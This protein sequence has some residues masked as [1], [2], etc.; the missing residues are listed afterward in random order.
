[1]FSARKINL[2]IFLYVVGLLGFAIYSELY[3]SMYPCPLCITQRFFFM[4]V[5]ITA[6]IAAL[7]NSDSWWRRLYPILGLVFAVIGGAFATRHIWLQSLPE[8]QVP[9]CGPSSISYIL[10]SFPA[11]EALEIL[12]KGDGNCAKVDTI[13]GVSYALWSFLGFVLLSLVNI[14]QIFR[15]A[16]R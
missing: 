2:G 15:K 14:Y 3:M 13:L 5:G 6:L 10:E 16:D 12:L 7:H 11:F 1:M 4:V 8:D 9:A